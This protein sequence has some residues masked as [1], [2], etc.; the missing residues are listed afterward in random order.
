MSF[1]G[2]KG[3][4]VEGRNDTTGFIFLLQE[5]VSKQTAACA[6]IKVG[7]A[8]GLGYKLFFFFFYSSGQNEPSCI[9]GVV[10]KGRQCLCVSSCF[11]C[12]HA[13]WHGVSQGDAVNG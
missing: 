8:H 4:G 10:G 9:Y 12:L 5:V 11:V 1:V 13:V 3:S 7:T 2:G 6:Q